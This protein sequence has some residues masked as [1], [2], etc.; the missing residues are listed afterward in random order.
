MS[1]E[2]TLDVIV[3]GA[4]L[5]GMACAYEV[6]S[7]GL[8]VAVLERGDA[9]GSKNLSG[10]RLYLEPVREL[11]GELL[12]DAPFERAVVSDSIVFC[13]KKQSMALRVDQ[14]DTADS[15]HSVTVLRAKLDQHLAD[16]VSQKGAMLLPQQQADSLLIEDGQVFGVKVGPEE[17]RSQVVVAADGVLSFLAQEAGLR[18]RR[19]AD[20][21]AIGI[22][23]IIQLDSNLIE[24]RFNVSAG[25][26]SARLYVGAV[27]RGLPGGGFIYTNSQSLSIGLVLSMPAAQNWKSESAI[28]DLQEAFKERPDVA[29]LIAGGKTIEYG[30]HLIP[31]GGAKALPAFGIPGLLLVGD[32][33]GLVINTGTVLRGMD[34]ALASG[35]MAGRSI[36]TA[37]AAEMSAADTVAHYSSALQ[38][39]F[40]M[41]QLH[42]H[43]KAPGVLSQGRLYRRYPPRLARWAADLF[44]VNV[45]GEST[46]F[47]KAFKHLRRKVL[48]FR[49]YRD[50]WRL[51]RM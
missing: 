11:C 42:K 32:A 35:V 9:A 47:K 46:S 23:E 8:G 29:P 14:A 19:P 25:K 38:Q 51:I 44:E 13:D 15:P 5:A 48:G 45:A 2:D 41:R 10:G 43:R 49:G 16:K 20:N 6:A 31:E 28:H 4:G 3:V 37:R 1:D 7:A 17:L 26:G 24:E 12:K 22:K 18:P 50:L 40:I 39:S 30:A 34:L 33:A 36:L 21:Y 27:T